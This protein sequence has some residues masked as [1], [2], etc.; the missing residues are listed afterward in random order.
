MNVTYYT[1]I[2]SKF[3]IDL[4]VELKTMR[5][6]IN[7]TK[8]VKDRHTENYKM[9]MKEMEKDKNKYKDISYRN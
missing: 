7:F 2:T 5:L 8:K 9:L 3:T 6:L 4:N 1:R